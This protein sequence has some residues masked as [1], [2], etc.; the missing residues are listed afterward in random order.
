MLTREK[1]PVHMDDNTKGHWL[2]SKKPLLPDELIFP[3]ENITGTID[4]YKILKNSLQK[5]NESGSTALT[6]IERT[7]LHFELERLK[8]ELVEKQKL[9]QDQFEKLKNWMKTS[10]EVDSPQVLL[11]HQAKI[12]DAE[13]AAEEAAN[14]GNSKQHQRIRALSL[15][16]NAESPGVS[17]NESATSA[18]ATVRAS[19]NLSRMNN[20]SSVGTGQGQ[21]DLSSIKSKVP[22]QIPINVFWNYI[23]PF[24]KPIDEDDLK[25][26]DDP[27][28]VMDVAPF[29]IPPLG[30][31]YEKIWF[32]Q[33]GY[34]VPGGSDSAKRSTVRVLSDQN[35]NLQQVQLRDRLLSAL[36]D[37]EA[38]RCETDDDLEESSFATDYDGA[39]EEIG[40]FTSAAPLDERIRGSLTELGL[41]DLTN[42]KDYQENDEICVE[43][44]SVQRQ[45]REQI[46]I[47][48]YRKKR[49]AEFIRT[50][51]ASQEFYALIGDLDKQIDGIF[52]RRVKNFK[53][54]KTSAA[55]KTTA[56]TE[57]SSSHTDIS[58]EALQCLENRRKL[59]DSFADIVAG[60]V[61]S[62]C[63]ANLI[64]F[65]HKVEEEI[66]SNTKKSSKWLPLPQIPLKQPLSACQPAF[67][68][69]RSQ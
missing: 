21:K 24:F 27:S 53:K 37:K 55:S 23:E 10:F 18:T 38:I 63:P 29:V 65:D 2:D 46:V 20:S 33:Y 62:L 14:Q 67:P 7:N 40:P 28:H 31:H 58:A 1:P 49:L 68:N 47:N 25:Y 36:S 16:S 35:G 39:F 64:E 57:P 26:L 61:E 11:D 56:S 9:Y 42:T 12:R 19:K 22:N 43:M 32:E 17:N 13:L 6:Q 15:N 4:D 45:L 5:V 3:V 50:K 44:R 69:S 51:L 54:K 66:I 48:Q 52:Q 8:A 41:T 59:L 60:R 30:L 34:V